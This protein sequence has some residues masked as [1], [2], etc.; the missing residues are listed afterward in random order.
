MLE[1][2]YS[3]SLGSERGKG[4]SKSRET[5]VGE[6]EA[7]PHSVKLVRELYRRPREGFVMSCTLRY[8]DH[9]I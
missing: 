7:I 8:V 1:T 5:D 3:W 2:G 9:D 6:E 4:G